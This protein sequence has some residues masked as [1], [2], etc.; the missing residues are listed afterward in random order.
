[1]EMHARAFHMVKAGGSASP[2]C[3]ERRVS[4]GSKSL[5]IVD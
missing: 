3:S 1:M 2:A 4:R 5:K